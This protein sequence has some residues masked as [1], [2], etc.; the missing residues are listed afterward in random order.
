LREYFSQT[1]EIHVTP[2]IPVMETMFDVDSEPK[3]HKTQ[4]VDSKSKA[5]YQGHKNMGMIDEESDEDDEYQVPEADLEVLNHTTC[6]L[7]DC[8]TLVQV[9]IIQDVTLNRVATHPEANLRS[10]NMF[11]TI[12][13]N[14][15]QNQCAGRPE[16][17]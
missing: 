8:F 16:Q 10:S 5:V 17:I 13:L 4:E 3:G 11:S 12:V 7:Y 6:K 9:G 15:D 1:D 14:L 2:R